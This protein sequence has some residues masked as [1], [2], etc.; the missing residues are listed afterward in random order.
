MRLKQ[1]LSAKSVAVSTDYKIARQ[2]VAALAKHPLQLSI[3]FSKTTR[4]LGVDVAM[5]KRNVGILRSRIVKS[6]R[7]SK[8]SKS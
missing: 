6:G 5:G 7:R 1:V 2:V 3:E 4:D 8:R